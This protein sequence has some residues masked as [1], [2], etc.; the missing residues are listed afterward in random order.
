MSPGA[1]ILGDVAASRRRSGGGGTTV[2]GNNT[3]QASGTTG[4]SGR[5]YVSSYTLASSGTLT[6]LHGY[7][8]NS[9][10]GSNA[11][12]VLYADSAGLP[13]AKKAVTS[14]VAITTDPQEIIQ[15]GFSVALTAGTYWVGFIV[16]GSTVLMPFGTGSY[17][18]ILSGASFATPP[19]PFGTPNTSGARGYCCWGIVA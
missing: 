6:E 14:S 10:G 13:G 3:I 9:G 2:L 17:Q 4:S 11:K 12:V 16:D 5:M 18:G 15:T 19:D 8:R 1:V 7:F